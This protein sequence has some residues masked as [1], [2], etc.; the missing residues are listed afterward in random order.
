MLG[1]SIQLFGKKPDQPPEVLNL[2]VVSIDGG[3]E[4]KLAAR[5]CAQK[6]GQLLL[7]RARV[8]AKVEPVVAAISGKACA[9]A[10][11]NDAGL[12]RVEPHRFSADGRLT[13]AGHGRQQPEAIG[14]RIVDGYGRAAGPIHE[15]DALKLNKVTLRQKA[16][17][18]F[19][20]GPARAKPGQESVPELLGI[21]GSENWEPPKRIGQVLWGHG[22]VGSRPVPKRVFSHDE[23]NMRASLT[24]YVKKA[25]HHA[26]R[27]CG[28]DLVGLAGI[29][30]LP[31]IA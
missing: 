3:N 13:V 26:Q 12:M 20:L 16:G 31:I 22:S 10:R 24:P 25:A 23:R 11:R 1:A 27:R 21:C 29:L 6:T 28:L 2:R 8:D 9:L 15:P 14:F 17:G 7:E 18:K 4:L 30:S 5:P 19:C